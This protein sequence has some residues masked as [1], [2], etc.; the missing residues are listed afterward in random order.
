MN[1]AEKNKPTQESTNVNPD[2]VKQVGLKRQM[3]R[4]VDHR[5]R[6][7]LGFMGMGVDDLPNDDGQLDLVLHV[8]ACGGKKEQSPFFQTEV[9]NVESGCLEH[10]DNF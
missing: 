2:P 10:P 4:V 6:I 9:R 3:G 5:V 7:W 1:L 8:R